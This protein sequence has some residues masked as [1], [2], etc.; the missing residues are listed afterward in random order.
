LVVVIGLVAAAIGIV[1]AFRRQNAAGPT[2]DAIRRD[3]KVLIVLGVTF[4]LLGAILAVSGMRVG[5]AW[6]SAG[7]I[8]LVV[9]GWMRRKASDAG[10]DQSPNN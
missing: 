9:G 6:F 7:V 10:T 3:S 8:L 4:A 5:L 2:S 1:A